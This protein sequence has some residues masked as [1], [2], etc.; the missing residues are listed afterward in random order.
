M[1]HEPPEA[2]LVSVGLISHN[3]LQLCMS[4]GM[5]VHV[6]TSVLVC[7]PGYACLSVPACVSMCLLMCWHVPAC[8]FLCALCLYVSL[9]VV[10][11]S[12]TVC[13]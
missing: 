12:V 1:K 2:E 5:Y 11:M 4:S 8:V 3:L 6:C 13:L 9:W 10:Y 7:L